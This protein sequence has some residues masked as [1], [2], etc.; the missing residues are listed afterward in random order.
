MMPDGRVCWREK[1]SF[2]ERCYMHRWDNSDY[3]Q[4][5]YRP[6]CTDVYVYAANDNLVIVTTYR[7]L[8]QVWTYGYY[9]KNRV[10]TIVNWWKLIRAILF[11]LP[12]FMLVFLCSHIAMHIRVT[13]FGDVFKAGAKNSSFV[14]FESAA[15]IRLR[16]SPSQKPCITTPPSVPSTENDIRYIG[17]NTTRKPCY[18]CWHKEAAR[19]R[20]CSFRFKV[21]RRH[22]KFRVAK[23]RKPCFRAPNTGAKQNVM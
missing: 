21:R 7:Q 6:T 13:K 10:I 11:S 1:S 15:L 8:R 4:C 18:E 3:L 5:R 22:Y 20:S 12:I 17:L 14:S 2:L 23:L 9:D 16:C 19:C